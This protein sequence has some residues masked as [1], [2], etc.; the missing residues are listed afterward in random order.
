M[1]LIHS[2]SDSAFKANVRTL[3]GDIGKS[4]HVKSRDQALAIA[5]ATKR[6]GRAD[7]GAAGMALG[8]LPPTPWQV[9]AE[10]RQMHTGPILSAVAG[11]T[12]HHPLRVPA[13]SYVL[14]SSHIASLGQDNTLAGMKVINHMFHSGPYGTGAMGVRK[15]LGFPHPPRLMTSAGGARGGEGAVGQGIEIMAAGGEHVLPPETVIALGTKALQE[16]AGK[17]IHVSTKDALKAGHSI[18][19]A[20]VVM[21]R[22]QHVKTLS[23]LPGPAK[24]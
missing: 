14:P 9:R 3:M 20:W 17:P 7:G 13:G 11:R 23:N 5:Y 1:P 12:D 24:A 6:R 19:D 16:Q 15:G 10:A 2:S 4:P 22:K 18:L 8:G 21:R